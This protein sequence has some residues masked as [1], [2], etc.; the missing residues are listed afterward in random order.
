MPNL[1][2]AWHIP[3][4]PEPRGRGAMRDPTGAIPAG[5]PVTIISGNQDQG[6]IGNPGNQVQD[7]SAV[8]FRRSTD[9]AWTEQPMI[10]DSAGGNNKY[11]RATINALFEVGV[12]L[13]YY[14]RIPY[15]D[16]DITFV[17]RAGDFSAT[18]EDEAVARQQP[19]RFIVGDPAALGRWGPLIGLPNVAVHSTVL[20]TGRV[21]MWGRRQPGDPDLDVR[22]CQP[23]LFDPVSGQSQL[24]DQPK[25]AGGADVN[26]FC[27][28]HAFLPDGRLLV[29]G[30]HETDG[31][32]I[33][34]ACLY[35]PVA[36]TWTPTAK[37]NDGRWYPTAVTLPDGRIL[38]LGGSYKPGGGNNVVQNV[39]PQVWANDAWTA[40]P[41]LPGGAPFPLYP[42]MHVT[43]PDRVVMSGQL[44]QT[45]T[46][47]TTGAGQ[48][49]P[50]GQRAMA[51]R[52]YCP[53]VTY[54][55]G[56]IIYLGGG[57]DQDNGQPTAAV[58][59]LDTTA[60]TSAWQNT[61]PMAFRRRQ[62]N[63]TLLA[64]GSVLV[65][66]GTR[67]AGFNSLDPGAPVHQA[68]LW[69]PV[70]ETWTTLAA[71]RKDRCYHAT[72]VLL[73]DG[74][75]LSAGGGEYRPDNNIDEPNAAVDSHADA[76]IF[77]PPYLFNGDRLVITAAPVAVGYGETFT[78]GVDQPAAVGRVTWLR[79]GSTTHSLDMNQRFNELAMQVIGGVVR[80]TAPAGPGECP[81]GHYLMFVISSAGVP[82]VASVIQ[83]RPTP[84]PP[85]A[86]LPVLQSEAAPMPLER[87]AAQRPSGTE[88]V[89]GVTGLCPYGIGACWAGAYEALQRLER[90]AYV[91]PVPDAQASTATVVLS[92]AGLPPLD[93]WHEQFAR[94][95][96]GS[97]RLRGAEVTLSGTVAVRGGVVQLEVT[98]AEPITLVP[99]RHED[100]VR[101]DRGRSGREALRP[102]ELGAYEGLL[103]AARA[104]GEQTVTGPLRS[105]GDRVELA[106]REH[107]SAVQRRHSR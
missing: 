74:R 73:P 77:S 10:F 105:S 80:A 22:E 78:V 46:L 30:G 18:T 99:I 24:T 45:W 42:R 40:A 87:A 84:A 12:Q 65:T 104:G 83:V 1:G 41:T 61:D 95:V 47:N 63:A 55:V 51:E 3:A 100:G 60:T 11:Y 15:S 20:P 39:V 36:N 48:W 107:V 71:E 38:V 43:G 57:N 27:A 69:E 9:S 82:S 96:N 44:A 106:V 37:M 67:G 28:G 76:Q 49:V 79:L 85:M 16:H 13:D 89:L 68:E 6:Q 34:Q 91:A 70:T 64:D 7:G 90:V 103:L 86:G 66:G 5:T 98:G 33:D 94:V 56:K 58:E 72:T 14:L 4:N 23:F 25:S 81:P 75:V 97:Y 54:A 62:H 53:A 31:G 93:R 26:L 21:L 19:F 88:V 8:I 29:M 102:A 52:D 17:H 32:G 59:V 50:T 92:D 35:D 101:L 2:N